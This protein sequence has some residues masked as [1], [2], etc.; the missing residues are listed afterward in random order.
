[1]PP[2]T[3]LVLP[4]LSQFQEQFDEIKEAIHLSIS[5]PQRIQSTTGVGRLSNTNA[6]IKAE[7]EGSMTSTGGPIPLNTDLNAN[8][9]Y[10]L[11][12]P[13]VPGCGVASP[14]KIKVDSPKRIQCIEKEEQGRNTP[15]TFQLKQENE[16]LR[17]ALQQRFLYLLLQPLWIM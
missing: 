1:M 8:S 7:S 3:R 4:L 11:R 15:E 10:Q 5:S 13:L 12:R 14:C 9:I 17:N 16:K 2:L 6:I